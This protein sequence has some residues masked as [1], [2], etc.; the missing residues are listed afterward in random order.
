[1]N[2]NEEFARILGAMKVLNFE[3]YEMWS[4]WELIACILHL[5]NIVFT[6]QWYSIL[7]FLNLESGVSSNS[8]FT[9]K[10]CIKY[11]NGTQMGSTW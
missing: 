9:Q 2:D 11:N 3:D 10:M 4:I 8:F 1:M 5:G 6:G 7:N